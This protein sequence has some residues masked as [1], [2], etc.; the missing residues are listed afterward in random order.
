MHDHIH[1]FFYFVLNSIIK[2]ALLY[3][4]EKLVGEVLHLENDT[5]HKQC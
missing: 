3:S 4:N 1:I 5:M 2:N